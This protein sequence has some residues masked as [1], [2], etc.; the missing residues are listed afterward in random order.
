MGEKLSLTVLLYISLT[1]NNVEAHFICLLILYE[2][3]FYELAH[4]VF[5]Y[6]YMHMYAFIF[7]FYI[8]ILPSI[9][10]SFLPSLYLLP[11]FPFFLP[12]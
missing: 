11:F 9:S 12:S 8:F 1:T 6:V 5:Y 10:S 3:L 2:L 7:F 4:F